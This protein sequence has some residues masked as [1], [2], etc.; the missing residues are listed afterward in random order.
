MRN[1]GLPKAVLRHLYRLD[2]R[3][4]KLRVLQLRS[5]RHL[6][7]V[8]KARSRFH[9]ERLR[10]IDPDTFELEHL[11][12]LPVMTKGD[13][14][15]NFDALLT[16]SGV[17]L[18]GAFAHLERTKG[19]TLMLG[20]YKIVSSAGTSGRIGVWA[21]DE[22]GWCELQAANM[23]MT[24]R[25]LLRHPME[26]LHKPTFAVVAASS[27]THLSIR[28]PR[29]FGGR[30]VK[31][32]NFPVTLSFAALVD[33]LERAKPLCL[34]GYPSVL[35]ELAHAS[36]EG[37][38]SIRPKRVLC[39]AEPLLQEHRQII[40]STWGVTVGNV[41]A[42]SEAGAM[43]AGCFRA[44]GMHLSED[45]ILFEPVDE[46]GEPV[47]PGQTA[48]KVYITNLFNHLMP[49]I[50][51]ELSDEIALMDEPC[52]CGS[53]LRRIADIEG[54]YDEM[55]DYGAGIKVHTSVLRKV[56]YSLGSSVVDYQVFQLPRGVKMILLAKGDIA[57]ARLEHELR[58]LLRAQ[59]IDDPHVEIDTHGQLE[60]LPTGKLKRNIPMGRRPTTRGER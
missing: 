9:A 45:Q 40:E 25:D 50:R 55:F 29:D 44:P 17:T 1:L 41:W 18:D 60:R 11:R 22:R 38:L 35:A 39:S 52:P 16:D 58:E 20:R 14:L 30:W 4:E 34:S 2:M 51:Y 13:V 26:L 23:R 46:R 12:S 3:R 27:A 42:S 53:S 47:E 5:V 7:R 57:R 54:R 21:Y 6:L 49:L 59:G 36:A 43:A 8:A 19:D 10:A 56:L 31:I 32:E 37:R 33:A 24:V 28:V 15:E 48:S